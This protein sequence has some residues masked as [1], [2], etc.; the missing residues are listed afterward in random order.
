MTIDQIG[1][2]IAEA[3]ERMRPPVEIRDKLDLG[4]T[5]EKNTVLLL[6][7]RPNFMKPDEIMKSPFAKIRFVKSK[8]IWKLYWMRGNLTWLEYIK[9]DFETIQKAFEVIEADK[10]SCFFG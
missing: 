9:S 6:E 5:F 10:H 1:K 4:F 8:N 7:I 2:E 3:V